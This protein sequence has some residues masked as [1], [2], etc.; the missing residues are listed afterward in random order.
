MQF[1]YI[2]LLLANSQVL[3]VNSEG[4]FDQSLS[5]N[6]IYNFRKWSVVFNT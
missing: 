1:K 3:L 6:K 2:F 4:K 5:L